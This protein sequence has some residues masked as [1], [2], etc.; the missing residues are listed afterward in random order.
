MKRERIAG[1]QSSLFD[2]LPNG[3]RMLFNMIPP[4]KRSKTAAPLQASH[5]ELIGDELERQAADR[6]ELAGQSRLF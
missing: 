4:G 3:K 1:T 2:E 6:R 5:L